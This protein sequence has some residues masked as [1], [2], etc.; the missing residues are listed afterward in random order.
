MARSEAQSV[1]NKNIRQI[2][3]D[4]LAACER[5]SAM[6]DEAAR[7]SAPALVRMLREGRFSAEEL[8]R[9][10]LPCVPELPAALF[11]ETPTENLPLAAARLAADAG[12]YLAA[13]SMR[14]TAALRAAKLCPSPSL[15]VARTPQAAPMR[16]A[17]PDTAAFRRAAN[18]LAAA[19]G[20]FE[21]LPVRSFADAADA[22]VGGDCGYC[23][24]PLENSRDGFLSTTLRMM[25]ES[26]LFVTRVCAVTDESGVLTRFALLCREGD[27]LPDSGGDVQVALRLPPDS[28][29]AGAL[30]MTAAAMA[31]LGI[32]TVRTASQP[33]GYTDGYALLCTFGGTQDALFAWLLFLA[34]AGQSYTPVGV[35]E[36]VA[37]D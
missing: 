11:C 34:L 29:D 21:T 20:S 5:M 9:E 10:P 12:A 22:V 7:L 35:Y 3:G 13:F 27:A 28:V 31:T 17:V 26:D 24:L 2:F 14:L 19:V 30:S 32:A 6:L 36:T 4:D 33:L 37:T 1:I 15:F 23:I 8:R 16:V 25:T 18:A